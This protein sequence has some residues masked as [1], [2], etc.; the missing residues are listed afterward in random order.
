MVRRRRR[1]RNPP[2]AKRQGPVLSPCLIFFFLGKAI[3]GF[4]QPR[5]IALVRRLQVGGHL[6]A[7]QLFA[8]GVDAVPI[9]CREGGRGY[10]LYLPK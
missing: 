5:P 3:T 10:H 6:L 4:H 7:N 8:F 2:R 1:L 9:V